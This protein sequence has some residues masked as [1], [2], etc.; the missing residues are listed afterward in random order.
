[1]PI[2]NDFSLEGLNFLISLE[3][4]KNDEILKL[5]LVVHTLKRKWQSY[6]KQFYQL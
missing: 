6:A 1:M 3:D 4:Y 5:P 2:P